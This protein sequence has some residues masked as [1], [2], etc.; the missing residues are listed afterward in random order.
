M[1]ENNDKYFEVL[2]DIKRTLT[3]TRNKVVENVNKELVLMYYNIGLKLAENNKWG[4][5]FMTH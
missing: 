4:S 3:I 5:S 1:L 2:N